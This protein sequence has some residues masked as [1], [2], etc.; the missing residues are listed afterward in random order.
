MYLLGNGFDINLGMK[1]RY[2]DFYENY[3]RKESKNTLVQK[4]KSN[5]FDNVVNWSDLERALGKYTTEFQSVSEFDEVYD[6]I[7]NS[8]CDYLD[9]ESEKF[10]YSCLSKEVLFSDL[11]NPELFLPSGDINEIIDYRAKWVSTNTYINIINFNYTQSI[12]NIL[13]D[14]IPKDSIGENRGIRFYFKDLIHIHGFTN[15]RTILGV[16]DITQVGNEKFHI[17]DDFTEAFIKIESNNRQR[18]LADKKCEN[19]INSADMICIFG[20]SLGETDKFWWNLIGQNLRRGIKVIIFFRAEE[21]NRRLAHKVLRLERKVKELFLGMS[22]LNDNE[23]DAFTKNIYV[24]INANIF[25][26]KKIEQSVAS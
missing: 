26:V 11:C 15:E 24:K 16:N 18:H 7:V 12:E 9:E 6:D 8:L 19:L 22:D 20:C 5:I 21:Q 25:E 13:N 3:L 17:D 14:S 10:D 1:T 23:R 4:L 2:S